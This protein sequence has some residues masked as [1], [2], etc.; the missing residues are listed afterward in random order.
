MSKESTLRLAVL[1]CAIAGCKAQPAK[2]LL[3][4]VCS[5][6]EDC[7]AGLVC[8]AS[9]SCDTA[10]AGAAATITSVVGN[11]DTVSGRIGS[12]LIVN[13]TNLSTA[14]S[15]RLLTPAG[16]SL[17][18]LNVSLISDSR[19]EVGIPASVAAAI[20]AAA[21][22]HFTL[23]VQTSV[24]PARQD[25]QILRGEAGAAGA[26]GATG[27]TGATGARGNDGTNGSTGATG[28]T[29]VSCFGGTC[30]GDTT[31]SGNETFTGTISRTQYDVGFYA[32]QTAGTSTTNNTDTLL[33]FNQTEFNSGTHF[34]GGTTYTAPFAGIYHF[35]ACV[36]LT[37]VAA[38]NT[39]QLTL[40][41]NGV[42]RTQAVTY[43]SVTVSAAHMTCLSTD[44]S[45]AASDAFTVKVL[46]NTG[47]SATTLTG[48]QLTSFSGFRVY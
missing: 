27:A 48:I 11:S 30:S 42:A 2:V 9:G 6:N 25:V 37:P 5:K 47:G 19:I 23:E 3:S 40:F 4:G 35:E 14:I 28:P 31:F 20:E 18:F 22:P 39:L 7:A 10:G 36:S 21:E 24:G 26:P 41:R 33:S 43:A 8:N 12:G 34:T 15:A 45:A 1:C 29:G 13:G 46:Q 16:I 44:T 32:Y 17:G 38:G